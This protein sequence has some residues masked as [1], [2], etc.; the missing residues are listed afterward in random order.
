M[1]TMLEVRILADKTGPEPP[2]DAQ[3][4][5]LAPWPFKGAKI[6]GDPP[7][8]HDFPVAWVKREVARGWV[9][10]EDARPVERPARPAPDYDEDGSAK[11]APAHHLLIAEPFMP[12]KHEFVHASYLVLDTVSHGVLRYRVTQQ[13]DKYADNSEYDAR[14]RAT[15]ENDYDNETRVTQEI[16]ENGETRVDAFY[17][18]TL[19]G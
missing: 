13:P 6:L 7:A 16:Y 10:L 5:L 2:K 18:C 17:R 11:I 14:G 4:N 9:T 19:E 3:G 12:T 8:E 15:K 1:G